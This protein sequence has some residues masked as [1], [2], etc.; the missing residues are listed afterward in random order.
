MFTYKP[1]IFDLLDVNALRLRGDIEPDEVDLGRL[2]SEQ[3]KVKESI[4]TPALSKGPD[5]IT[6]AII[7]SMKERLLENL[8]DTEEHYRETNSKKLSFISS[9]YMLGRLI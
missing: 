4:L 3:S 8:I 6:K 2:A 9:E 1:E 5:E 7:A